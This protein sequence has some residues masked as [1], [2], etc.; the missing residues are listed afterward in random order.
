MVQA[1]RPL[2]EGLGVTYPQYLVLLV[3]WERDGQTVT[4][5]GERL[6]LDSGTLTP[7]LRRMEARGLVTRARRAE[8][9]RQVQITLTP[10]GRRLKQKAHRVPAGLFAKCGLTGPDLARLRGELS[11]LATRLTDSEAATSEAKTHSKEE[12][13]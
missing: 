1:Y 13:E 10:Q 7:L 12:P 2:L 11:A 4:E 6:S 8:D 3:L 9:E 5:L